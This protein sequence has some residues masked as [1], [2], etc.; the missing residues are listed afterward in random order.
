MT[1]AVSAAVQA[2]IQDRVAVHQAK[3]DAARAAFDAEAADLAAWQSIA[4]DVYVNGAPVAPVADPA[5]VVDPQ[6]TPA[7]AQGIG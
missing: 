4:A 5:P 6:P 7:D 2:D 3:V 1:L